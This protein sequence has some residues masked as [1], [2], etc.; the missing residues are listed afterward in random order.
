MTDLS[1]L[2]DADL[3]AL[4]QGAPPSSSPSVSPEGVRRIYIRPTDNDVTK[5]SDSDLKAA[6]DAHNPSVVD[7]LADVAKSAGVGLAKSVVGMVGAGGDL[8]AA[9]SAGLDAA[10]NKLGFDPSGIK[11]VASDVVNMT[12]LAPLNEAPT[13]RDIQSG[14][15]QLTGPFYQPKT[16]AGDFAQTAGEFLPAVIGGPETLVSKLISRVAVP[17]IA[18]EGA[19][20]LTK[21]TALEP[22]AR[23]AGAV[24]GGAGAARALAPRVAVAPTAEQLEAAA[25]A[26]YNHPDV[27]ALELHPSSTNYAAGKITDGLNR[28]GFRQLTAPQTFSLVQEL[29]TSA[30]PTAKVADIQSVRTALGKVAGNFSNPVEQNA[31]NKAIRGVDDYLANLKPFDVAA[32]DAKRAATVLKE[33]RDNWAAKSRL[34]RVNDA[35]Y[36]AELNAASAHSGGNVNNATRQALKSILTS[37]AKRRGYTDDEIAQMEH[38]VKGTFTGNIARLISKIV[39]VQGMHGGAV[40]AGS[41]AAGPATHGLSLAIPAI[42][43]AAKKVADASTAKAI[44]NLDRMIA[45]RSPFG[46]AGPKPL[47]STNPAVAG[48]LSG[49]TE[50]RNERSR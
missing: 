20:Q 3:Q 41:V 42:G 8:R 17:A 25:K 30:G 24:V 12:P 4:Y 46:L 16:T 27:A 2:S 19:G 45:M 31:A 11:N 28:S 29:K 47:P 1:S 35:E 33:A 48:L 44:S 6:Y 37:R 26:G 50:L 7:T 34:E 18:S 38:V 32:G 23:L 13:S 15:E 21:G 22:A 36:R 49:A 40:V 10:G 9:A 39:S 5:M 14:I 43:L